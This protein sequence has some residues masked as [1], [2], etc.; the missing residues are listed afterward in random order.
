MLKSSENYASFKNILSLKNNNEEKAKKILEENLGKLNHGHLREILSLV[1][2]PYPYSNMG[3]ISKGPWFGRLLKLNASNVFNEDLVKIN[4]WFNTLSDN[5]LQVEEKLELL[6][7]G[8]NS[9]NGLN[10]G[11]ITLMLYLLDKANYLIWFQGQ[12]EGLSYIYPDFEEFTG[13]TTQYTTF[14]ILAKKFAKQYGFEH[15]ELDW[16]FTTGIYI[17]SSKTI[18]EQIKDILNGKIGNIVDSSQV[19]ELLRL[20]YG[21]NASSIILSDYCYNRINFGIKFNKHLFEYIDRDIYKYFGENYPYTGQI[22]AKPFGSEKELVSGEWKN[23]V[24]M[25]YDDS[26]P[27]I[28]LE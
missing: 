23:E 21:T 7:N 13:K 22:Y 9:I 3:K 2:G 16:V 4:N 20:K 17:N 1:D 15:S 24:K 19:K 10:V 25:L 14:N 28:G 6:L 5:N 27:W 8:P 12:H 11:F 18:Y 26:N